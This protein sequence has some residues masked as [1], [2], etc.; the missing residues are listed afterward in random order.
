MKSAS[1]SKLLNPAP[2]AAFS[3]VLSS[4]GIANAQTA[5]GELPAEGVISLYQ[6]DN[7]VLVMMQIGD[8]ELV[9]MVFDTGS[10]GHSVDQ[11]LVARHNLPRVGDVIEVDGTTGKERL[12]P[13]VAINNVSLGGLKVGSIE[14]SALDYDRTD[15]MGIITPEMFTHSLVYLELGKNRVRLLPR[16]TTPLPEAPPV[17]YVRDIATIDI[18]MPDGTTLP[19]HFDSGY[20]ASLSLPISMMDKVSLVEPARVVGRF[21]SINTEGE[22]YGGQIRGNIRIGPVVLESPEVTFLG[23]LAN[24]G[25]PVIRQVTLVIDPAN[26]RSW[27]LASNAQAA[28]PSAVERPASQK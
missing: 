22:V 14:A 13:L 21:K 26:K 3:L 2:I 5:Q 23:E 4:A 15:A 12:L 10:D 19:A 11:L 9:P 25:L 17:P 28:S 8:G 20:N 7:R 16:E 1:I 24:I 27:T 6:S 18:Q